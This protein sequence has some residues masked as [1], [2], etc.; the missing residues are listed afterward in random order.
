MLLDDVYYV[1]IHKIVSRLL[2]M[3]YG[4]IALF[5]PLFTFFLLATKKGAY[6]VLDLFVL[7]AATA[8]SNSSS[9]TSPLSSFLY[10]T[11]KIN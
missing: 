3:S 11:G 1:E 10:S 9:V 7:L 4:Y 5:S 8:L 2:R 6:L